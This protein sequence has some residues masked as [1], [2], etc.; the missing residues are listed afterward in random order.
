MDVSVGIMAFNEEK[1]MGRLL[2]ALLSQELKKVR[3]E[4]I[5]VVS[6]GSTDKTNEIVKELIEYINNNLNKIKNEN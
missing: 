1:N 5:I 2:K 3:I 4:E 6:D